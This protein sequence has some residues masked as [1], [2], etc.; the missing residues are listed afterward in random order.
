MNSNSDAVVSAEITE[1]IHRLPIWTSAITLKPLSGGLSNQSFTVV[2]GGDTFVVRFGVDYP[3]HHVSRERELMAAKAAFETGLAPEVVHAESGVMVSRFID[4][5][6][7]DAE[8]VAANIGRVAKLVGRFHNEMPERVSG[9]GF[10][11]WVFHVVR[12]YA[13]TLEQGN[14]RKKNE[15]SRYLRLNRQLEKAQTPLPIIYGHNDLLP[16][17]ILDDGS[18]LWLIDFE[19]GGFST[20]MFDLAG[21]ASNAQFDDQQCAE[22]LEHYFGADIAPNIARSHAAMQCASLLREAMWSMVSELHLDTPGVDFEAYTEEN[23]Q[24]LETAVVAYQ[25]RF[26][27]LSD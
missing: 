2:D 3:F 16:A 27:K 8:D 5:R 17:N 6:T 1:R 25:N 11:F 14:S 15:L 9:A 10:M 20:A 22:L 12:D 7:F 19:Y 18:R 21:I 13:A 23:L 24:R 4:A 26:G